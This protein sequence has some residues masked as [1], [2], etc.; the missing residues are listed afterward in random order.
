MDQIFII[1]LLYWG[2]FNTISF[3]IIIEK[4]SNTTEIQSKIFSK[5]LIVHQM[6]KSIKIQKTQKIL[7][8]Q[9]YSK[10]N[11]LLFLFFSSNYKESFDSPYQKIENIDLT[12]L[13]LKVGKYIKIYFQYSQS[14][15][16]CNS[17]YFFLDKCIMRDLNTKRQ[18]ID[19][20]L[21]FQDA[22]TLAK[23]QLHMD[24]NKKVCFTIYQTIMDVVAKLGGLFTT[25][26]ALLN[27]LL[28]PI[29][30]IL[31]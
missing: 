3:L 13:Y 28:Q 4:F 21:Y 31:R 1:I 22:T 19:S 7:D 10:F 16:E 12:S 18:L 15:L 5:F 6:M 27:F 14:Y 23:I 24:T 29:L 26:K 20:V 11:S 17:F 2:H 25:I 8:C 30:S 9:F